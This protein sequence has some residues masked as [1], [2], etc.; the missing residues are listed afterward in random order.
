MAE[1][2]ILTSKVDRLWLELEKANNDKTSQDE[3]ITNLSCQLAERNRERLG[4]IQILEII[5]AMRNI[6]ITP[7]EY[8]GL[9]EELDRLR[10]EKDKLIQEQAQNLESTRKMGEELKVR[11]REL[12]GKLR[13]LG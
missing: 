11:D 5:C 8:I 1:N 9:E 12:T 13:S 3:Q 6:I 2:K 7:T 10:K 4:M